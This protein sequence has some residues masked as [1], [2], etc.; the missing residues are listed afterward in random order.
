MDYETS[1]IFV[2]ERS[3]EIEYFKNIIGDRFLDKKNE[4]VE[5][6]LTGVESTNH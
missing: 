4:N 2:E 1:N 5:N 6:Y 3:Q